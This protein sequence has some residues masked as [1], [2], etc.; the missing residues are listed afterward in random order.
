MKIV[1]P[2]RGQIA[3]LG[4]KIY[5]EKLRP[6]LEPAHNGKIALINIETGE[7]ELDAD[8]LS[9]IK[10]ARARWPEGL[11]FAV[12]IGASA[13]AHIGARISNRSN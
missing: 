12:R 1:L 5:E 7:C 4:S 9:A 2:P 10:R 11:F 3:A 13:M 8:H 6:I